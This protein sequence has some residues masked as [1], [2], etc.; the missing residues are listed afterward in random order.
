VNTVQAPRYLRSVAHAKGF[1]HPFYRYP[2][3]APPELVREVIRT[4]TR[5]G[6]LVVDPF[7]GGGTTIVEAL[8]H[9]RQGIGI[10]ANTLA[11]F[12]TRAKTT[13][14][15]EPEWAA[16]EAWLRSSPLRSPIVHDEHLDPRAVGLP[17]VFRRRIAAALS[18]LSTIERRNPRRLARCC[19]LRLAQWAVETQFYED[20][21]EYVPGLRHMELKLDQLVA[22][23]RLGMNEF[24]DCAREHGVSKGAFPHM[25]RLKRLSIWEDFTAASAQA[26]RGRA[27]LIL[28]SP[29]Y[30]GVHVLY[31]RWQVTSRRETPAPYWIAGTRDGL[32]PSYY[33]M[34]SR[35]PLG[36]QRY[37]D[38]LVISYTRLRP[39]LSGDGLVV[40]LVAFSKPVHQLPLF[41]DAMDRA[42]YQLAVKETTIEPALGR[43]VPNRR[44]YARGVES[45]ASREVML[46]H[47]LHKRLAH[48]R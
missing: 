24:V 1:T 31:H 34:G 42:G 16:V 7:M 2:A 32:G 25:R 28:T 37:F 17:Y 29:P 15:S 27:R 10:D 43:D 48:Q 45:G 3:A 5:P 46:V 41:L 20:R 21:R 18:S 19:L 13:P 35:T 44:W 39:L 14:L 22:G 30:P 4:Y 11:V 23:A 36:Q 33:M 40:Q 12:V 6:E 47:S 9:G 26:R 38:R 8:A